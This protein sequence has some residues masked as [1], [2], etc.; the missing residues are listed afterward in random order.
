ME[1][2]V[3]TLLIDEAKCRK[4][5]YNMAERA[6]KANAILRPHF[7]THH[8][9]TIAN[10]YRDNGIVKCTV[11]SVS[12]AN[13]FAKSGWSDI[14][15]AFPYNPLESEEINLLAEKINLNIIL[16]S[17]ESLHHAKTHIQNTLSY[18]LKVDVGY[19]RTGIDH[20][21]EKALET[22]V[23]ASSERLSFK[24]FLAHA[25]HTYGAGTLEDIQWIYDKAEKVLIPLREKFGGILSYGDTPSCSTIHD[26]STYDELRPGNFVFY[27]LT[28]HQIGS[29]SFDEIAV[30]LACP[31]VAIHAERNE[32]VLYGG[33]V[34][35]SKDSIAYKNGR[36]FGKAVKLTKKGWNSDLL[37]TVDRIS[38]EHGILKIHSSMIDDINIGD[39]IGVI[40]VHSCLTADIQGHYLSTSGE[41]IEKI[42]KT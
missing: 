12:M 19:H 30:C 26:L 17:E 31:V 22:L 29:C 40:P 3:P 35:L 20:R 18:F 2:K 28:Q 34:H 39:I 14:T 13:Y 33:A 36:Y 32:V 42:S 37:G 5:I 7:K 27:D 41:R 23:N 25:G 9:A 16:E 6:K 15:I 38:Q 4:N 8:S 24:G 21:N 10:W 1:I 11:S